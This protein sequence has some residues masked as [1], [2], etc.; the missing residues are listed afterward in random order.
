MEKHQKSM[1]N[2]QGEVCAWTPVKFDATTAKDADGLT[3]R[4]IIS[5]AGAVQVRW[6][7]RQARAAWAA[8][9]AEGEEKTDAPEFLDG[10][11]TLLE[12]QVLSHM[13]VMDD[14]D[15]VSM[16][17]LEGAVRGMKF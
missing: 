17:G 16:K 15:L 4:E 8:L 1:L 6:N 12:A 10:V 13:T 3:E 14:M 11:V 9:G 7:V 2:E 5:Y